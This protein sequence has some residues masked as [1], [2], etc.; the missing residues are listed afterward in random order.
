[1]SRAAKPSMKTRRRF[2]MLE[3]AQVMSS[4]LRLLACRTESVHVAVQDHWRRPEA[5]STYPILSCPS[6][7]VHRGIP[8]PYPGGAVRNSTHCLVPLIE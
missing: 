8:S 3:E 7:S 6:R 5:T 4:L 2:W 1:M